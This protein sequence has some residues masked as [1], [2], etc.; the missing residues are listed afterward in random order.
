MRTKMSE[1]LNCGKSFE[2]NSNAQKHCG[3]Q[4]RTQHKRKLL[5]EREPDYYKRYY[6][7]NREARKACQRKSVKKNRKRYKECGLTTFRSLNNRC[8]QPSDPGFCRYGAKGIECRIT[9]EQ[10]Q[11]IFFSAD[12]CQI[13]DRVLS[14]KNRRK[15]QDARTIDR[16]NPEGHYEVGNL[17]VVCR[18]C[19][20]RGGAKT[21]NKKRWKK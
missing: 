20:A 13:C 3:S 11:Q 1:C 16:I 19:N 18:S 12:N 2:R 9:F 7:K 5:L 21:T 8:R 4:C 6:A 14:D 15:G 10:F 17:R